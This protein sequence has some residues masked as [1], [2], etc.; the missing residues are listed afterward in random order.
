MVGIVVAVNPTRIIPSGSR[1]EL[2]IF[3]AEPPL[4]DICISS[5]R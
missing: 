2:S 1:R 5:R 3:D 4:V